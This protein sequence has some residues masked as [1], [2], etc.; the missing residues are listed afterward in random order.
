MREELKPHRPTHGWTK[1]GH[2]VHGKTI[3]HMLVET[4]FQ[5]FNK[6]LAIHVTKNVGTMVCFYI[7]CLLAALS[8]PATFVLMGVFSAHGQLI[9]AFFLTF[10][11][12]YLITW[13]CQNFIQLVLLPLLM[14]GQN[15]QNVAADVRATK[16]FE[17]VAAILDKLDENTEGGI[18][19]VLDRLGAIETKLN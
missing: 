19:V 15:L 8:L 12:I 10:G 11:W 16:T 18:K 6:W 1:H 14:V 13:I 2:P 17:D 5:R 9:P 3:D 4:K 7:F